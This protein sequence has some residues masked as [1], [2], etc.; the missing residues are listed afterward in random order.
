MAIED[1]IGIHPVGFRLPEGNMTP[2]TL[3]ILQEEGFGYDSSLLDSDLPYML[4]EK[5]WEKSMVEIPMHWEMQDF[6]YFAFN[7]HPPVPA[8]CPRIAR[9]TDVLDIWTEEMEAYAREGLCYVWKVDPQSI[10]T[11]GRIVLMERLLERMHD[12]NFWFALGREISAFWKK[13]EQG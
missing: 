13:Q 3:G 2:G 11:P 4:Q 12:K 9:Y 6:P 7:Y 5:G 1:A 8:G 10:G